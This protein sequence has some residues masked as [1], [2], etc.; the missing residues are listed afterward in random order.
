MSLSDSTGAPISPQTSSPHGSEM[1]FQFGSS[2]GQPP[3]PLVA[4][5]YILQEHDAG[6]LIQTRLPPMYN[7]DWQG[8]SQPPDNNSR[9]PDPVGVIPGDKRAQG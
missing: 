9:L 2:A 8:T 5:T 3:P 6:R 4:Q 1:P 7:E